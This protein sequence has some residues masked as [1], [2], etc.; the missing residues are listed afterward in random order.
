MNVS[1][2]GATLNEAVTYNPKMQ[3]LE[4]GEAELN[5]VRKSDRWIDKNPRQFATQI[6]RKELFNKKLN[7]LIAEKRFKEKQY[8]QKK[9]VK[10]N[11]LN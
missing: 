6:E 10:E 3:Q 4:S 7:I 8:T 5:D 9:V 1:F 2:L 11:K